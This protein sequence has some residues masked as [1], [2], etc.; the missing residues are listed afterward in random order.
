MSDSYQSVLLKR[1]GAVAAAGVDAGVAA[2]YGAPTREARDLF[3]GK[4]VADLSHFDVLQLRGED[5]LTWLDTI[6][7]QRITTLAPGQ[8][9]QALLLSVQG[10]AEHVLNIVAAEDL[11]WIITEPQ[12]GAAL[13]QFMDSMRFMSRVEIQDLSATYGVLASTVAKPEL[14]E[15]VWANPW[16]NI[17]VGGFAYSREDHP[18]AERDWFEYIVPLTELEQRVGQLPL[19]GTMAV[20]ALRI[21]AWEPRL[22]VDTDEKSIPHELDWLRTAVHLDK[23]CYK[24]QE[25][26]ARVHNVGHPP[27]RLAMLHLD[28]SMHTLPA[29]GSPVMDGERV[30]G[31]LSSVALHFEAGPIGLATLRRTVQ[32]DAQLEI[33]DGDTR[34]PVSQEIIVSPDAGQVAGRFTGFLRTPRTPDV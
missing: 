10:R 5:R 8:S 26:I 18:G 17:Q 15:V 9:T 29:A 14:G 31:R 7:S 12:H 27:R 25:T 33:E 20:E 30:V 4:A 23:G 13:A 3:Q 21:A 19:A 11:L 6:S 34:Y 2:H 1:D 16:P 24:G 32:P 22:G 28:G